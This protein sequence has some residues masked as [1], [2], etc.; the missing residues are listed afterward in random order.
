MKA[1]VKPWLCGRGPRKCKVAAGILEFKE[2]GISHFIFSGWPKVDEMVRFGESVLP[3]V[4][5]LATLLGGHVAVE[6]TPGTGS[7]FTATI[8]IVYAGA[9]T[10]A[11]GDS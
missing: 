10:A 11:C 3:L 7:T 1:G 2:A 6:S 5:K 8:P 4:R 9:E